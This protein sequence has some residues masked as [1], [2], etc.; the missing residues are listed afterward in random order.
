[1]DREVQALFALVRAG[2]WGRYDEAMASVFPL[3]SEEWERVFTIARQQTVTGIAFR[4][5]DLLPEDMLPS[6]GL[7]AK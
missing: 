3:S 1:M 7:M 4:G 6:M 5:L 2:L